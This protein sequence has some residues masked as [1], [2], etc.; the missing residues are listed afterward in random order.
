MQGC[1]FD[2]NRFVVAQDRVYNSVVSELKNGLKVGHWM[3]YVFPQIDG[4]VRN[5]S[6]MTRVYSISGKDEAIQYLGHSTLG[7]RLRECVQLVLDTKGRS[8][9]E[10]LG[11][12]DNC[13]FHSCMTLFGEVSPQQDVFVPALQKYFN[14]ELDT[15]TI[16]ILRRRVDHH[17]R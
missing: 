12:P 5:P 2:L 10:I 15:R 3:W 14:G 17:H 11:S 8:I 9:H 13:K 16:D 1:N 4:I 6:E 7:Q